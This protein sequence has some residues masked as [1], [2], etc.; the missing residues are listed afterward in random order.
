MILFYR[1]AWDMLE[2]RRETQC[3]YF[4]DTCTPDGIS[5]PPGKTTQFCGM[6]RSEDESCCYPL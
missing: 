5:C 6:T 2:M 1:T 4:G 3:A